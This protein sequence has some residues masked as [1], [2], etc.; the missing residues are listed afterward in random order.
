MAKKKRGSD[1]AGGQQFRV[2]DDV[3]EQ[4]MC[5]F[6]LSTGGSVQRHVAANSVPLLSEKRIGRSSAFPVADAMQRRRGIG[7]G[8]IFMGWHPM[9]HTSINLHRFSRFSDDPV[10]ARIIAQLV[11][12]RV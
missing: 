2:A 5:D 1:A 11:P 10:E 7:A 9:P 3:E 4:H 8:P 6:D 12:K